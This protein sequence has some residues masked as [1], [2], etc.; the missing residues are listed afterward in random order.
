MHLANS[1]K[2]QEN[3]KWSSFPVHFPQLENAHRCVTQPVMASGNPAAP[4][5]FFLLQFVKC[6]F[7]IV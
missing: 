6:C 7:D 1:N 5:A 3:G 2:K 4:S